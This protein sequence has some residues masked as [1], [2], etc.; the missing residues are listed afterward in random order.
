MTDIELFNRRAVEAYDKVNGQQHDYKFDY[1][2]DF[3]KDCEENGVTCFIVKDNSRTG[4]LHYDAS[5]TEVTKQKEQIFN[6]TKL[7]TID[8]ICCKIDD[9]QLLADYYIV[10]VLSY[11]KLV[12]RKYI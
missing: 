7:S 5:K 11:F 6:S 8:S 12:E 2:A 1:H 10:K 4:V 9:L 3:I